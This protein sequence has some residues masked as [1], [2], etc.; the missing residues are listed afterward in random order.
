MTERG[1]RS[2]RFVG[3]DQRT[4]RPLTH[5]EAVPMDVTV[6]SAGEATSVL[7][8][9]RPSEREHTRGR[10][11]SVRKTADSRGHVDSRH[12]V[13][14]LRRRAAF[15]DQCENNPPS[16]REEEHDIERKRADAKEIEQHAQADYQRAQYEQPL[17]KGKAIHLPPV[18]RTSK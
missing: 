3:F 11:G 16:A 5:T 14:L 6:V 1:L 12:R 8:F 15:L 18:V 4:S 13:G 10:F 9:Q 17:A 7:A 2:G